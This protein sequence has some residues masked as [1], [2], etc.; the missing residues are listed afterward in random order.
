MSYTPT[1]KFWADNMI[2]EIHSDE[3]REIINP[4]DLIAWDTF[5][6]SSSVDLDTHTSDSGHTWTNAGVINLFISESTDVVTGGAASSYYSMDISTEPRARKIQCDVMNGAT[7][8][9]ADAIVMTRFAD[10]S[11]Y[12]QVRARKRNVPNLMQIRISSIL[13][14]ITV[15]RSMVNSTVNGDFTTFR[16]MTIHDSGERI[17]AHM[18]EF[19]IE[20]DIIWSAAGSFLTTEKDVGLSTNASS[21]T[22]AF[23]NLDI[24]A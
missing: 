14:G 4:E 21:L 8:G 3:F 24:Y 9:N 20:L 6:E 22:A 18:K 15:A 23:D 16:K 19:L 13:T 17:A 1:S 5:T 11:N 7:S 2:G 12:I 10:S